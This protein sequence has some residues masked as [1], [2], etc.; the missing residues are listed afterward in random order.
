MKRAKQFLCMLLA[1]CMVVGALPIT[2]FAADANHPFT[3]VEAGSWYEEAVEYV[4]ANGLMNGISD[5]LFDPY[6]LT[7]RAMLV[8]VLY[9]MEGSPEASGEDFTDVEPDTWYG[10]AVA[11]AAENGIVLGYPGNIFCPDD[12]ITREQMATVFHRYVAY[13]GYDVSARAD[14]STYTDGD[15]V[16][17]WA[18]DA[19]SWAVSVGLIQGIG[20]AL[21]GYES[22]AT[23]A[24]IAVILQRFEVDVEPELPSANKY[25]V[26]FESNGGSAVASQQV[27]EGMTALEPVAPEKEGYTFAGWYADA[28]LTRPYSFAT[29]VN[30][31]VTL[32]AAW[33]EARTE[34]YVT[35]LP[36][37]GTE[38]AY[39]TVSVEI[40]GQVAAPEAP[41]REGYVFGGWYLDEQ[42]VEAYDFA[43]SVN[44][45]LILFAKW[46]APESEDE[47]DE[48]GLYSSSSGGGTIYSITGITVEN[49]EVYTT[50]NTNSTAVLYV[51]F[52][53]E[54]TMEVITS[55]SVQTPAYCEMEQIVMPV[56]DELP[57]HF[58]V[59]ATLYDGDGNE[60]TTYTSIKYTTANEQF[61]AQTAED[62]IA[63]GERVIYFGSTD[64]TTNFGVL[65]DG[66]VEIATDAVTNLI[67]VTIVEEETSTDDDL[68]WYEV[69]TVASPSEELLNTAVGTVVLM[70]GQDGSAY[71]FKIGA[72]TVDENG[73]AVIT[74][75]ENVAL[76]EFYKVVKADTTILVEEEEADD[77]VAPAAEI[78]DVNVSPSVSL[79]GNIDW[80]PKEHV[81][82]SGSLTGTG[83]VEIEMKYDAHLFGD[84][85]F[86]CSV[87]TDL[88]LV[89]DIDVVLTIDNEDTADQL[90]EEVFGEMK[91]PDVTVPTPVAGLS[92]F[93]KVSVPVEWELSG[94]FD[95]KFES[96]TRSGFIYDTN[97]GKQEV[98][99]KS[100][101]VDF[102]LE[103]K[104][105]LK[106][107]P[108]VSLGLKYLTS[109]VEV[110][111]NVWGG[112]QVEATAYLG[113]EI[114][115]APSKHAC[116]LC[117]D[118][119]IKWFVEVKAKLKFCII[120]DVLEATPINAT[121]FSLEGW[122]NILKKYPGQFYLSLLNSEDSQFGGEPHF[123]G[124]DCPNKKYRVD[125][126]SEDENGAATTGISV[127]VAKK[128]GE[129]VKTGSTEY[130]VYL[131][132]GVYN[133]TGTINNR[134][135]KKS[136]VVSS[137]ATSVTL[138]PSA[139]DG[140]ISGKIRNSETNEA[141]IGASIVISSGDLEFATCTSDSAGS[142]QTTLPAGTYK[143]S[144]TKEGYVPFTTYVTVEEGNT[145][146]LETAMLVNGEEQYM[147]G[148]SGQIVN[149]VTGA[150]VSGVTLK[151]RSGW[152]NTSDGDV[153]K[154]LTT[155]SNGY[156]EYSTWT[157]FGVVFGLQAGNYTVSAT[158]DGYV[159]TSFN[160]V[161][162]AGETKGGQ[163]ATM[164][165]TMEGQEYRIVLNWGETPRD[166]DSHYNAVTTSGYR[167]HIYYSRKSGTTGN[168]D[169]DDTS[170][171]GP[172]TVTV[173]D[174]DSLQN[175][176]TYSVHDY[177]NRSS[178]SST[179][180]SESGAYVEVY[181]GTELLHTYYVPTGRGGTVWNVFSIDQNG[182]L[183]SLNTFTYESTPSDVGASFAATAVSVA[184]E[185]GQQ[186]VDEL[187]D[188]ELS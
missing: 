36:N 136:F 188:Y 157:I 107:G 90:G 59:R 141:V 109:V 42:G 105:S 62:F 152:N 8:T 71:L 72:M 175:G 41:A 43:A 147:G 95:F 51:E 55:N 101:Q 100:R 135:V 3:D 150:P 125:V 83:K 65:A 165:P 73:N 177:T 33:E 69:Y 120:E 4:Y 176:F 126:K 117:I 112:A 32:Y 37:D 52:L 130:A 77:G 31:N 75:D 23:R 118:G 17:D 29:A 106:F 68:Q 164:S 139:A 93:F 20:N 158:K 133:A 184:S 61:E 46:D 64:G 27:T 182:R 88:S 128:N 74:P 40:G 138:S 80:K 13:K 160:V 58:L 63:A 110:S 129:R 168:L 178:S 146:Y 82:V 131:Y 89:L 140:K 87:I 92:A 15:E 171:Y 151:V 166:L 137:A 76:N 5:T 167:D 70:Y 39:L 159:D 78:I 94:G 156:F 66:V 155:D 44:D 26:T 187:K 134:T 186:Q 12:P 124:G 28:L 86:M 91:L 145:K 54:D 2:A 115:N 35:F 154:T 6:G 14:L 10:P 132:N 11:W 67:S 102:G 38:E 84:D 97:N 9:R 127:E 50:V 121:L 179:A 169:R 79:G 162:V 163:N 153:L 7:T 148:F 108:K 123:G 24:M 174:F 22:D 172:E 56:V 149:A 85:Y 104:A 98:D 143:V 183:T 19:M 161:V 49:G 111:V 142:Y 99:E 81:K 60:L 16:S 180:L 25:T 1:L 144:I 170:S 119:T 53:A 96:H 173:T 181:C 34:Y 122:I 113:T 45:D 185:D 47:D 21:L 30:A 103:G 116:A 114:T 18:K 48:D 57:E